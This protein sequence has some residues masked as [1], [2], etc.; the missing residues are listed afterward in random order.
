MDHLGRAGAT[1]ALAESH[2]V[3]KPGGQL[4][5]I[6]IHDDWRTRLAFGPLLA[7]GGTYGVNWWRD[8]AR[9]AG[10]RLDEEGTSTATM[11]FLLTTQ[12]L[13]PAAEH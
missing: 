6:L 10:F 9:A 8:R 11:F 2:R 7:H 3:I 4:L 5:L 12:P 1:E 13:S